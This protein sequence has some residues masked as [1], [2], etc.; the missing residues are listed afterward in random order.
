MNYSLVS[1]A[2]T[3]GLGFFILKI[4]VFLIYGSAGC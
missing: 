3:T 1:I 4:P 2:L